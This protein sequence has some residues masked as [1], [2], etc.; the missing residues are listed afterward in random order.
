MILQIAI[1]KI[2]FFTKIGF[3]L[4]GGA[5]KGKFNELMTELISQTTDESNLSRLDDL[6]DMPEEESDYYSL[7]Q[8]AKAMDCE[9]SEAQ[10]ELN[11]KKPSHLKVQLTNIE[12]P[13]IHKSD[14]NNNNNKDNSGKRKRVDLSTVVIDNTND[15]LD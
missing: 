7:L 3:S 2:D 6:A 9:I 4:K 5:L 14:N 15:D 8:L 11:D 1:L 13:I 12:G 10:S